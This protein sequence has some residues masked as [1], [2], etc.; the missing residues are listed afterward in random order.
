MANKVRVFGKAQNRTVQGIFNAYLKINPNATLDELNR[1]FPKELRW[2]KD[3]FP[4][5]VDVNDAP[6]F[7]KIITKGK[8]KGEEVNK[9]SFEYFTDEKDVFHLQD[10]TKAAMRQMWWEDAFNKT[11]KHAE[12]YGIEVAE[13]EYHE[14]FSKGEYRLEYLN[15]FVPPATSSG[16]KQ[17]KMWLWVLLAVI[18]IG[19]L[20]LLLK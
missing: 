12:K 4:L 3:E 1:A 15:G 19:G 11:V 9:F 20:I 2:G 5:F 13:F 17:S 16:N 10:G 18:L 8:N 6:K 14:P 7:D